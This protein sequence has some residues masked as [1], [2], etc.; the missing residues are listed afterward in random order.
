[1]IEF[2]TYKEVFKHHASPVNSRWCQRITYSPSTSLHKPSKA[3][4]PGPLFANPS[5]TC[6]EPSPNLPHSNMYA[7]FLPPS[8][9]IFSSPVARGAKPAKSS[10]NAPKCGGCR[11]TAKMVLNHP[12]ACF[13][14]PVVSA[15]GCRENE[16]R[17]WSL[18]RRAS[19][20]ACMQFMAFDWPYL[21][22]VPRK[23]DTLFHIYIGP[24]DTVGRGR[25]AVDG[26]GDEDYAG[27]GFGD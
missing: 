25:G 9:N 1:M 12:G 19:S 11:R 7:P 3:S 5:N 17:P 10:V 16:K 2:S 6:G 26:G 27:G 13:C 21:R 14:S 23:P 20:C 15:P 18:Y 8:S 4:P 24:L 22:P